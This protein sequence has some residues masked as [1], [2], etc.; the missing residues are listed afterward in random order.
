MR[1]ANESPSDKDEGPQKRQRRLPAAEDSDEERS[2]ED[3]EKEIV[4]ISSDEE[5]GDLTD[6]LRNLMLP[7]NRQ[8]VLRELTDRVATV[9]SGWRTP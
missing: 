6:Q 9:T 2:D 4:E 8:Q 3:I 1:R 7:E 5:I